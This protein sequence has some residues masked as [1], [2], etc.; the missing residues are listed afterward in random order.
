[1]DA[2]ALAR[3]GPVRWPQIAP[4]LYGHPA[5][6]RPRLGKAVRRVMVP[7]AVSPV[8]PRLAP[9][10]GVAGLWISP[11]CGR[12]RAGAA[13]VRF[14]P[15]A[16][17]GCGYRGQRRTNTYPP[18]LRWSGG[19]HPMF[20]RGTTRGVFIVG[21]IAIKLALNRRGVTCNKYEADVF[22]R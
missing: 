5:G 11:A 12:G 16:C 9:V 14:V 17:R 7:L 6:W 1:M 10:A 15:V 13:A 20:R 4:A 8:G 2:C 18:A 22:K 21:P 19:Q 3:A